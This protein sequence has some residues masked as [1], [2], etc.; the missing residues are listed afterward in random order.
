[1]LQNYDTILFD[2]DRTLFDTAACERAAIQA[3]MKTLRVPFHEGMPL[4]YTEINEALWQR[5]ET[6]ELSPSFV[7][8]ERW[9]QFLRE[10]EI[11]G[12]AMK[13]NELYL[14]Y[15]S[16]CHFLMPH[17][18]EVC[19]A[20]SRTKKL[21]VITNGTARVQRERFARSP[22]SFF[23]LDF[24]ISDDIGIPKPQWGFF[25]Y[26]LTHMKHTRQERVLIVGDSLT[27]DIQGGNNAKIDACWYNPEHRPND[28][29]AVCQFEIDDLSDLLRA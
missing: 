1:M 19:R 16:R 13:I 14:S 25:Y 5:M 10:M 3:V 2:A 11:P 22:L 21:Y 23:F 9:R 17:A 7:Q 26:V 12:D 29:A 4:R 6:G 18:E 8:R 27:S 28:T 24:F 20:L 15:F